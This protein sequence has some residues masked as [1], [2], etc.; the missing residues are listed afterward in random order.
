MP[1]EPLSP[2]PHLNVMVIKRCQGLETCRPSLRM[3]RHS[4]WWAV[5][6]GCCQ[7]PGPQHQQSLW[8]IQ[9]TP[10]PASV[11]WPV[12]LFTTAWPQTL[13]L[14]FSGMDTLGPLSWLCLQYRWK[15][16]MSHHHSSSAVSRLKERQPLWNH[17]ELL[18]QLDLVLSQDLLFTAMHLLIK[19]ILYTVPNSYWAVTDIISEYLFMTWKVMVIYLVNL[20]CMW[21]FS[22]LIA[23]CG[24]EFSWGK[25]NVICFAA[26]RHGWHMVLLNEMPDEISRMLD[27]HI[28][29]WYIYLETNYSCRL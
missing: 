14:P 7:I 19:T 26:R 23:S 21:K 18:N 13:P 16:N 1:R 5:G 22:R 3:R 17:A 20:M 6:R 29:T 4:K 12:P 24:N 2:P 25:I 15:K 9:Y 11:Y 27:M 28:G 10:Q 8:N